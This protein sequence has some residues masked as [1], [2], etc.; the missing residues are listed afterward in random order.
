MHNIEGDGPSENWE[1]NYGTT[2]HLTQER[3]SDQRFNQY[4]QRGGSASRDCGR[5][6]GPYI[7]RPLYCI[8][9]GSDTD[10]STKD[11]PIYLELKKK[12]DQDFAKASQQSAP[13]EVNQTM[14]WNAHQQ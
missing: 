8:Y 12:M 4:N 11:C 2:L 3:T 14:Q 10:H 9:H 13:R 1:K 5:G 6:R 7:V